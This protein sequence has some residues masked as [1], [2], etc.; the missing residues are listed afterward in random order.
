MKIF[1]A[2]LVAQIIGAA[3]LLLLATR[4][5]Q[6]VTT[7]RPRPFADDVVGLSGRTVDGA[8]T[9]LALVALAGV[10]AVI[11]T[12]GI[13]RRV[14]GAL[15]AAAGVALLW[16]IAA[17]MPA[18]SA[19]RARTLVAA[20]HPQVAGLPRVVTHPLWGVLSLPAALLVIAAG[21]ITAC[22]GA[23]WGGLSAR[24]ERPAADPDQARARADAS[25][26]T[27]LDSGEDPTARDPREA[28]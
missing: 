11:A 15:V 5:W 1:A 19:A 16:R 18:V 27:A 23:R 21:V 2:A 26:W 28:Q 4:E 8:V 20:K 7:V 22:W 24:H 9:A 25:L 3:A 17:A 10:V 14:V 13:A 12:K 6:T